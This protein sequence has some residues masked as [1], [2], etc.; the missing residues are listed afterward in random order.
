MF[1]KMKGYKNI[2]AI[3]IM[4][5]VVGCVLFL[6]YQCIDNGLVLIKWMYGGVSRFF[7]VI[8]PILWAFLWAYLLYMPMIFIERNILKL[9]KRKN[10][11]KRGLA[12][13]RVLSVALVFCF[14]ILMLT[15]IINFL[16]PPF[17]SNIEKF[18]VSIPQFEKQVAIWMKEFTEYL[19]TLNL[20]YSSGGQ[21]MGYINDV[22]LSVGQGIL[23][24]IT[25]FVSQLSG[26][27]VDAVV[28]IILT[29]Y[30]LKDKD[31]LFRAIDKF[32]TLI[33]SKKVKSYIKHFLIDIDDIVGKFLVGSI[34]ASIV[35]G[36]ISTILMI[37]IGHPFAVL[38]GVAAGI[39]N[40][41][42]YVGPIIGAGL[43]FVLGAFS[44]VKLGVLGAVLLLLYQ[45][46]DGNV[47]QPKIVGDKVGIA[48]V[49]ILMAVLVGG[50]YFGG[51]GMIIS[52]PIAGLISVYIDRMYRY[53]IKS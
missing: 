39:T 34:F 14:V 44:S 27:V 24:G 4:T 26:F 40:V 6:G 50:S 47:I 38:I 29:F 17:V 43:A 21:L 42:P 11:G 13:I 49:W 22:M 23:G 52:I 41:I 48:P 3:G 46:V 51:V 36:I 30:F 9:W 37:I 35:V 10:L 5:I 53:K 20:D 45:Q 12:W 32:G 28:T 25:G 2:V 8:S 33:F 19:D 31:K 18:I 1:E 15:T 7:N 16:V